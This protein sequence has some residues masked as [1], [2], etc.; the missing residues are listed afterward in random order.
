MRRLASVIGAILLVA[1]SCTPTATTPP[2][3]S[4]GETP[5]LGGTLV[6]ATTGDPKSFNPILVTDT[7]SNLFISQVY[8]SL[9]RR[10][11]KTGALIGHLAEK[12]DLSKD[13]LTVTYTVRDGLV[14]SDGTPFTGEDYKY[15]AEAT[16]RSKR[17][18]RATAFANVVGTQDYKDGKTDE[19]KG[20]QVKDGGKSIVISFSKTLCTAV[21]DLSGAGAGFILPSKHF[22][23][24]FDPRTTDTSKTIDDNPLNNAPPASMG[25][26]IFKDFKPGDRATYVKNPKYYLGDPLI[27]GLIIKVYSDAAA[28]KAALLV[29]EVSWAGSDPKDW[30]ELTKVE[31]LKGFEFPTYG[32]T[33]LAW[34]A[35]ATKAPWLANKLVRQAMWYGLDRQAIIDKIVF[36]HGKLLYAAQPPGN[37]AYKDEDLNKYTFNPQKAKQ[38]LEQAGAK[39]GPDG[40]YRWTDGTPL[41]MRI[42]TNQPNTVR[43]T[44]LQL[45]QEQYKQVGIGIDA[46]LMSF[47]TLLERIRCCGKDF[48]GWISGFTGLGPDPDQW[49][50]WHSSHIAPN[51]F[52]RWRYR[53]AEADRLLDQIHT[54]PDCGEVTRN[55]LAHDVDK[56]LN[57]DVPVIFIYSPNDL[58][59]A[60]KTIQNFA[61]T[62][63][64]TTYNIEKWWI[65][66]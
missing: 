31:S 2:L 3:A 17:T 52:N 16:V 45:A 7:T 65:K 64:S 36:G 38:L 58:I 47:N 23:Q 24:Y 27:D 39:M 22:K 66:K 4:V 54:G 51:E 49:D 48:E 56:L 13:G 43:E 21:E 40:I 61:P 12:F 14:W 29:G 18:T 62:Q 50:L 46:Q 35:D 41:K 5:V 6:R 25:P 20:I 19:L 32:W 1:T 34:N 33:Y 53:S 44:M 9:L 28:I 11:P 63:I 15:T 37:A 60:Q 57:E 42:E 26:W 8:Q 30:D 59:F 55:K 10:D